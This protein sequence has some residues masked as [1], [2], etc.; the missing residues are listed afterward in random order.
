MGAVADAFTAAFTGEG[1]V[2]KAEVAALGQAIE[3]YIAD[4]S[5]FDLAG[6]PA[7]ADLSGKA[8]WILAVNDTEDGFV[9]IEPP[10]EE[11]P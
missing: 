9:L 11:S 1:P 5:V 3:D 7:F 4:L 10:A 6:M 8:G 2:S